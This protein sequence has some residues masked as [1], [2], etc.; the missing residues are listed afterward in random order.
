M[1]SS[2]FLFAVPGFLRGMAATLDMGATMSVF[3]SSTSP[4]KADSRAMLADW[5]AV[6][7]DIQQV[8]REC[9]NIRAL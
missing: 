5:S 8:V 7:Q 2:D 9:E 1:G 4:E 6:G 3:N